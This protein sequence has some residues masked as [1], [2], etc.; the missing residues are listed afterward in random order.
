MEP[1]RVGVTA[2]FQTQ[3]K[4]LIEPALESVLTGLECEFLPDTG[5]TA[6]ADVVDRYDAVIALALHFPAE[7][8]RRCRRLAVIAR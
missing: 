2:D 1:F 5:E 3:A 4:G 8:V 6:R 7:S